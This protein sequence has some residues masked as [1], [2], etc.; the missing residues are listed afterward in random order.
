MDGVSETCVA[1]DH[2][3]LARTVSVV[4]V[5]Y[6]GARTVLQTLESIFGQQ[7]VRAHVIV[8][9]DGSTDGSPE[10]IERRYPDVEIHREP[11][12]TKAV[13]RLRNLGLSRAA[14][15]RVLVVDNDVIFAPDCFTE[16]LSAMD[17]DSHVAL[18]IPRMMYSDDPNAT[19]MAGGRMHYVGATIAP[20]RH[21][22]FD[23]RTEPRPAIGGGIALFDR[24]SLAKVGGFDE[25]YRL[26]WG[27]DIELHQRLLLAGYR[28]LYVPT[29]V[30]LH[31]YKPFDATR[32]YRARGQ[33]CNRWRYLLTHYEARTLLMIAPALALYEL[34]Q[35]V[36]L[37]MKG[38]PHLY[39]AGTFDALA[40]LP[41]T[42]RRRRAVQALRKV[43]DRVVLFAGPLY[44]RPEHSNGHG[45]AA[46]AV[47]ALSRIFVT[48]WHLVAP[49]LSPISRSDVRSDE[50]TGPPTDGSGS[51]FE[52]SAGSASERTAPFENDRAR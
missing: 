50:R 40:K 43:S 1:Q 2:E 20:H 41:S 24:H 44:V 3:R 38:M 15:D 30:C 17:A 19:Y 31:E 51:R 33:V 27:D 49:L 16:L 14:A 28:S 23:G 13:N 35:A 7:G 36:F 39:L 48:Y 12:N 22:P 8:V 11:R 4:V 18:C 5:N 6:N 9:D 32:A 34:V 47:A 46:R 10:T 42:L 52:L 37:A 29:A 21:E 45:T 25:G 26:A